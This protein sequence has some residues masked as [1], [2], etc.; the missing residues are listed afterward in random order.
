MIDIWAY[1]DVTDIVK[2]KDIDGNEFVGTISEIVDAEEESDDYGFGE[3]SIGID[4][5]QGYVGIPQ[6]EIQSIE[7]LKR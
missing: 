3:D 6:S 4:C 5:E 1:Q 2:V 7:I